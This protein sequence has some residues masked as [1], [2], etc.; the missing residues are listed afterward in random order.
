MKKLIILKL[1]IILNSSLILSQ[2]IPID[3]LI[4]N[5]N[6]LLY[7]IGIG[8]ESLTIFSP[9]RIQSTPQ[10]NF[11]KVSSST[12]MNMHMGFDIGN[13]YRSINGFSNIKYKNHFYVFLYPSFMN[14]TFKNHQSEL[15][16]QMVNNKDSQSG[17]GFENDWL[18][19]QFSKGNESWGAG[20]TQLALS[21]N[22]YAYDYF[23]LGSDYGNV[24]VRYIHGFLENVE[25]NINRYITARGLEWTNKRTL[26]MGFSEI[27]IYSGENRSMDIGYFNPISSHLE[28]ELNDRLNVTGSGSSNGVW[29]FHLDYL[30]KTNFRFSI[31]YLYDEFVL[32][33]D[34]EI[35]KEHGKAYSIRFAYTPLISA[36]YLLTIYT[37]FIYVGTPTFRH[38]S[39]T[40]NFTHNGKPL[41]WFRGSD[42]QEIVLGINYFNN[43]DFIVKTSVG[44]LQIGEETITNRTLSPVDNYIKGDFP[45]GQVVNSNFIE[46]NL[47][48]SWRENYSISTTLRQFK[49]TSD[50]CIKFKILLF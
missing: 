47:I 23:L 31:N 15:N 4:Y 38:L 49:N 5:S 39:G 18:T 35:G 48:Y 33:K 50:M 3:Y 11:K 28:I 30:L 25:N 29:Q 20:N 42:G 27:V 14:K 1:T 41:G 40:N 9:M 21:N 7:D 6:K 17:L 26:V 34:V 32:D 10:R 13:G 8:W 22:S 36:D 45:S 24:R 12:Q 19:L 16:T 37:S 46:T 44:A 2:S 43:D